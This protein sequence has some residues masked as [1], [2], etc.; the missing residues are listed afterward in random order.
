ME[1]LTAILFY[2]ALM[3]AGLGT[4]AAV[5]VF[6]GIWLSDQTDEPDAHG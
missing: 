6:A 2:S 3:L 1:T 5:F 4:A